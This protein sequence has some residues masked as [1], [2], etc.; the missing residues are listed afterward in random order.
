MCDWCKHGLIVHVDVKRLWRKCCIVVWISG[1]FIYS[2]VSHFLSILDI[3]LATEAF[4]MLVLMQTEVF[5]KEGK[6]VESKRASE[7]S[8]FCWY[9]WKCCIA[10]G[11]S[12]SVPLWLLIYHR[13][14]FKANFWGKLQSVELECKQYQN[15]QIGRASCRERVYCL[16]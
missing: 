1:T 15:E 4:L 12:I 11:W 3:F 10:K 5:G 13:N 14:I 16:V 8:S 6:G 9:H 2:E 7:N